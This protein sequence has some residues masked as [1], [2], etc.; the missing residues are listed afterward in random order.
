LSSKVKNL[1]IGNDNFRKIR[2]QNDYYIDK[3][4]MVKDFIEYGDEV[5]LL[6]D[7]GVSAKL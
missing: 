7:H 5:T 3:T 4:L 2:E 6:R 1:P